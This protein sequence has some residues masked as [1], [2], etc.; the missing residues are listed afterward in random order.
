MYDLETLA[1]RVEFKVNSAD[2]RTQEPSPRLSDE[3]NYDDDYGY[4][5]LN[6]WHD[7]EYAIHNSF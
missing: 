3:F 1:Y 5:M 7:R 2:L 4:A 6:R